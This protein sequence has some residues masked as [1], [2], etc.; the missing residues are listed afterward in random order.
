MPNKPS[1]LK[2]QWVPERQAF[3]NLNKEKNKQTYNSTRWRKFS[4]AYKE[5]YPLCVKCKEKGIIS[6]TEVT[7]H[8]ERVNLG[9]DIYNESNLQPLCKSCHNSKSGKEAHGYKEKPKGL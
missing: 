4:K 8:I 9:G 5:R 1:K 7:D 6:K 2:R 3:K